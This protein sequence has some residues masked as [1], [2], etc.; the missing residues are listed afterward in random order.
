MKTLKD[1]ATARLLNQHL[2]RPLFTAPQEVV[3]WMGAMQAQDFS[4]CRWAVGV[5]M[6]KP[7]EAGVIEALNKGDIIR[8]HLNRST[9]QLVTKEDYHWMMPLHRERSIRS[10]C[11]FAKQ[12]GNPISDKMMDNSRELLT[13]ILGG[14]KHLT[15]EDIIP[16][17]QEIDIDNAHT[18]RHLLAVA[19]AEGIIHNGCTDGR[20][21]TYRLYGKDENK[22][23]CLPKEEALARLATKYFQ[24][25]APATLADFVWWSGLPVKE[26]R[27]GMEQIS[28]ALTVKMINGTEYFLHESNR[29]GKMQKDSI[30]LLP[31]Y[32][33]LLIGYKDRSAVLSMEHER[34]AYNT[35]G[36]FYPV[37]L[38]EHRIAGNWSRKE[39][40]VTFFENDKPDAACLE[41]AKK[42]YE[43]FVNTNR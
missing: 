30:T 15:R 43:K 12:S 7:S 26:C 4:M 40:S 21:I 19:E 37:V 34:K 33:E 16:F 36:I 38:H 41:K 5:R 23:G 11:A 1:I 35:F 22:F 17:Y 14:K 28:S 42:Q 29:Y 3:S 24:S 32:D 6:R 31:P 20:K 13:N 18:V 10:W 39:L 9:W 27:I 8:S 25:H 2:L